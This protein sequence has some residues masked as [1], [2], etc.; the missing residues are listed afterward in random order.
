MIWVCSINTILAELN[1][2]YSLFSVF[3]IMIF[4]I[5]ELD[6]RCIVIIVT[7]KH[8]CRLLFLF[9]GLLVLR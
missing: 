7:K 2:C 1:N 3:V 9:V 6:S 5:R 4:Q 8:E